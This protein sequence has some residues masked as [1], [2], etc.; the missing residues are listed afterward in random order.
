[1][2][3]EEVVEVPNQD[4]MSDEIFLKHLEHRHAKE[5]QMHDGKIGRQAMEA[6]IGSY[7][8]FHERLHLIATPG[9]YDHEHEE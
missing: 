4:D 3:P 6:W 8:A 2:E 1:M 7:R 9:Q 5:C